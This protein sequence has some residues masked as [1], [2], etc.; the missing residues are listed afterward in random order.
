MATRRRSVLHRFCIP[1]IVLFCVGMLT[2]IL[3]GLF[4]FGRANASSLVQSRTGTRTLNQTTPTVVSATLNPAAVTGHLLIAVVGANGSA[5]ITGPTNWSTAIN[6]SGTPS[7]AI[8]YTVA[9]GGETTIT[10]SVNASP[11]SIGIQ[12]YEYVGSEITLAG[13]SSASGMSD[14]PTSGTLTT[15]DTNELLLAAFTNDANKRHTNNTWEDAEGFTE[16]KDFGTSGAGRATGYAGGDSLV[17]TAGSHDVTTEISA[18]ANWRGQIVAFRTQTAVTNV[19]SS[20]A[21]GT[22]GVG[23]AIPVQI[24]FSRPVTVDTA[25]G[26]PTLCLNNGAHIPYT[27]GSGTSTLTFT[28]TVITGDDETSLDYAGIND[29]VLNGG[30][31]LDSANN[32]ANLTL[33]S[34]GA[35]GSLAANTNIV[36]HTGTPNFTVQYFSD[37]ALT[38]SLGDN[39]KLKAGTYYLRIV[40]DESLQA[41]PTITIDAEGS[42]NDVA[43][44]AT[45]LVSGNTYRYTRTISSDAAATGDIREEI[46]ITGSDSGGNTST[47]AHPE[48]ISSAAAYT[49]TVVPA[50]PT[51]TSIAGDN[52]IRIS[53]KSAIIV[54]GTAEA[55]SLVSVALSDGTNTKTGSQ[56]LSGGATSFSI[57]LDGTTATPAALADG[58]ITPSVT[59]TDAAGNVSS[60]QATPTANQNSTAPTL[61]TVTIASN[62]AD[63]TKAK[64]GDTITLTFTA[65]ESL[66]TPNVTFSGAPVAVSGS[67]ASWS[68]SRVMT[69]ADVEGPQSFSITFADLTGNDGV[70]VTTTTNGSSVY[71][72]H[73]PPTI[74]VGTAIASPTSDATPNYVFTS[75]EAGTIAYGGSCSSATTVAVAG[76]NT[77]TFTSL[78]DGTYTNCTI[79][80]TDFT[81]NGSGTL[82]VSSFTVDTVA[83]TITGVSAENINGTYGTGSV[84][85]IHVSMTENVT[86]TGTPT[87]ALN[88]S[89]SAM[90]TYHTGSGTRTVVFL[91]TVQDGDSSVDLDYT[92]TSA[93]VLNGGSASDSAG[94]TANLTLSSPGASGSLGANKAIIIN[95]TTPD[96]ENPTIL[97]VHTTTT[98]GT[99]GVGI[100]MNI[101]V[102][103]D[104]VVLVT[105][106]PQLL[107]N[108][109]GGRAI[110]YASGSETSTI[111]FAYITQSGDDTEDL[112]YSS[113]E[114]LTLN[115]GTIQ[116]SSGN[117]AALTL[118]A[119][120]AGGSLGN[121][122]NIVIHTIPPVLAEVT[123][124]GEHT[125][126]QTPAYTFSSSKAGTI[127]YGGDCTSATASAVAGSNTVVFNTL[128]EGTHTNC[129]I[130]VTDIAGNISNT[131]AVTSFEISVS[132]PLILST[133]PLGGSTNQYRL[134]TV[135]ISFT[136]PMDPTTFSIADDDSNSYEDPVWSNGNATVSVAHTAWNGSTV[137]TIVID[138]FDANGDALG[139]QKSWSF[140]TE[141]A[142]A[143]SANGD[144]AGTPTPTATECW[145]AP[146]SQTSWT[147]GS[148]I[149]L[150]WSTQGERIHSSLL[151]Y[152]LDNRKT[153]LEIA[154]VPFPNT[155]YIWSV[156]LLATIEQ[157][158]SLRLECRSANNIV[159]STAETAFTVSAGTP[160]H[161]GTQPSSTFSPDAERSLAPTISDDKSLQTQSFSNACSDASR[162]KGKTSSTVYYC[163][164]DGLRY[165]F[166]NAKTYF[167]W[168]KTFEGIHIVSDAAL[169]EIP[170]GSVVTYRPGTR[171]LKLPGNA[172]V[173]AVSK[174][175]VLHWL[176]SED[177]A[178]RSYGPYW[179][180]HVDDLSNDTFSDY[181]L[182][183]PIY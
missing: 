182:G 165:P 150:G 101:H 1:I 92:S 45:T 80:V 169:E 59:A 89:G 34:P 8:F 115:G 102:Q 143:A 175:G 103:F 141:E 86:V 4:W 120:G 50:T 157:T 131:L 61:P 90:G 162:I 37:S 139:G 167:S 135:A 160:I 36:I 64:P 33:A 145:F 74:A 173:F 47:D 9:L 39:P 151:S 52:Y 134:Y 13:A 177:A 176:V 156:P 44:S 57:T 171:L 10:A 170:V 3:V 129:T 152:S 31:I 27:G 56:Q 7:Q 63:T 117:A 67:D 114:S 123:P 163:G 107:L 179:N 178:L 14:T 100:R 153:W 2:A 146:W 60:A 28:Y 32:A 65:S 180:R 133:S 11:G 108:V 105:G 161:E 12:V 148:T 49:D 70:T 87:I 77:V 53:E 78:A 23:R 79:Q 30:S 174:G 62:N 73:T 126:D 118:P 71:C 95:T 147:R 55:N 110:S 109:S 97:G 48:N 68:A 22:Y 155:L 43:S 83:P 132:T 91:Y 20:V 18:D 75:T 26:T 99:Y 136:E 183:E 142:P 85:E 104:E 181:I 96:T 119:P 46:H 130:V 122:A 138:G 113:T 140:T 124:V 158:V 84:I 159:R 58:T 42:A 168:Y 172:K 125:T 38:A 116:D 111:T 128:S 66:R 121:H 72:D 40:A 5:T 112:D 16:Q 29:L 149:T 54:L 154:T 88:A 24:T 81:G 106:T 25:G 6:Q 82:N 98:N 17:N 35:A 164:R 15:T 69:A 94:N 19:T 21:D 93:I 51:I 76:S 166:P 41:T 137:V 144:N 127:T